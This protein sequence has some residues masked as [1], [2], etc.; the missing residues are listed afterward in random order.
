MVHHGRAV[1]IKKLDAVSFNSS[2]SRNVVMAFDTVKVLML[3]MLI[4]LTHASPTAHLVAGPPMFRVS[5]IQAA[6]IGFPSDS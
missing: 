5:L 1:S 3:A 2:E 6:R 4:L